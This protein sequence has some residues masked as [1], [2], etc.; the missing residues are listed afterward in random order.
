MRNLMKVV[1]CSFFALLCAAQTIRG[2]PAKALKDS[3]R[4]KPVKAYIDQEVERHRW[5][6]NANLGVFLKILSAESGNHPYLVKRNVGTGKKTRAWRFFASPVYER[7]R[8]FLAHDTISTFV[9]PGNTRKFA[10]VIMI[11]HEWQRVRGRTAFYIGIDGEVQLQW[12]SNTTVTISQVDNQSEPVVSDPT[13]N[14]Y[15]SRSFALVPLAGWKFFINHRFAVSVEANP[16]FIF[17][18]NMNREYSQNTLIWEDRVRWLYSM[19]AS[20]HFL[21]LS[22]N[23]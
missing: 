23:F 13:I 20:R 15:W 1:G 10:P 22:Y 7:R 19:T 3:V 8:D 4:G 17:N 9:V 2:Q 18:T 21:N 11:G 16:Q 6:I 5:E 12:G 14:R